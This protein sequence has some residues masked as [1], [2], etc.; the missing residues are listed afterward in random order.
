MMLRCFGM[1]CLGL[2]YVDCQCTNVAHFGK[3]FVLICLSSLVYQEII[4][5]RNACLDETFAF[6]FFFSVSLN[7]EGHSAYHNNDFV[8]SLRH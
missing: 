4:S 7:V 2:L 1:P 5:H 8:S 3:L 6:G